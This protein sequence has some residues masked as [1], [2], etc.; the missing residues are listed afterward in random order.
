MTNT[1]LLSRTHQLERE[2]REA[3]RGLWSDSQ[4]PVAPWEW[5]RSEKEVKTEQPDDPVAKLT[6][7]AVKKFREFLQKEPKGSYIRMGVKKGG[8][9]GFL[10]DLQTQEPPIP[11]GDLVD[12]SNGFPFVVSR[13][14][15]LFLEGVT[16]RWKQLEGGFEFDNPNAK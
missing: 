16:I 4:T 6:P 12:R 10:Y 11:D 3:K 8:P 1:F 2:A 5:R 15:A 14:D 7:E 9:T 13:R